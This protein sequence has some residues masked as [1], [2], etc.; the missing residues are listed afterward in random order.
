LMLSHSLTPLVYGDVA[1]DEVRGCTIISTEQ[2]FDLEIRD[3]AS[4]R[5]WQII[6]EPKEA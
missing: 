1:L 3:Y 4:Q 6:G 5:K 2:I